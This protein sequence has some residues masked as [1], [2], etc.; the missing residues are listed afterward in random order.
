M[1]KL[2]QFAKFDDDKNRPND[3]INIC[4][5]T[6]DTGDIILMLEM[7]SRKKTLKAAY[8]AFVKGVNQAVNDGVIPDF[9][10]EE[11]DDEITF[12]DCS[13]LNYEELEDTYYIWIN[14]PYRLHFA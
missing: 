1:A 8:K 5:H 9:T 10:W 7:F 2:Y 12:G 3:K 13:L 11:Y 6:T 14:F 4:W